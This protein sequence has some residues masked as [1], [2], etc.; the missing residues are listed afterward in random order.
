M[1]KFS[2]LYVVALGLI[3]NACGGGGGSSDPYPEPDKRQLEA[4]DLQVLNATDTYELRSYDQRNNGIITKVFGGTTGADLVRFY[5]ERITYAVTEDEL[6][7]SDLRMSRFTYTNWAKDGNSSS[8]FFAPAALTVGAANIGTMVWY[9]SLLEREPVTVRV[10][11]YTV[12]VTS[13][14]VGLMMFGEGYRK[15]V[16]GA[17][18]P[19][20][21]YPAELRNMILIHE[22]RHSDCTG[23]VRQSDLEV[24]RRAKNSKDFEKSYTRWTCGHLHRTCP[25]YHEYEGKRVCDRGEWGAYAIG[26]IY[27][28][29]VLPKFSG[30]RYERYMRAQ[31]ID[32]ANRVQIAT[33]EP[34]YSSKANDSFPELLSGRGKTGKYYGTPD[35]TSSGLLD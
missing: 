18:E 19:G 4:D 31:A 6:N 2:L 5:R 1:K 16:E 22:A 29:A 12:N 15:Y 7:R 3:L 28:R 34:A 21:E 20:L 33:G 32:Q 17:D 26:A 10:A 23:G 8:A 25:E 35:M 30:T 27:A 14:R 11:N 24:M 13:S 9:L